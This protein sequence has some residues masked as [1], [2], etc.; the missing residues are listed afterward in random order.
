LVRFRWLR[1]GVGNILIE[2]GGSRGG[3]VG[4]A[5]A[6][7]KADY[8]GQGGADLLDTFA[9]LADW[10][11]LSPRADFDGRN[12]TDLGDIFAFLQTWFAGCS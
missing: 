3:V 12:G 6:C 7:C 1:G 9:F 5:G 2:P 4:D 11:A 8:N 10:F